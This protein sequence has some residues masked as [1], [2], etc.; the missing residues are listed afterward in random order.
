MAALL[1]SLSAVEGLLVAQDFDAAAELAKAL[2]RQAASASYSFERTYFSERIR[3]DRR[4]PDRPRVMKGRFNKDVGTTGEM[5]GLSL[6]RVGERVAYSE[7]EGAW[8][9]VGAPAANSGLKVEFRF[10]GGG[11]RSSGGDPRLAVFD[12]PHRRLAGAAKVESVKADEETSGV[13]GIECLVLRGTL[14]A[15]GIEAILKAAGAEPEKRQPKDGEPPPSAPELFG[16]AAFWVDDG[17]VVRK[18]EVVT[19]V[20]TESDKGRS[21]SRRT[22]TVTFEG[23]GETTVELPR[24]AELALREEPKAP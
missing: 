3:G 6:A 5:E 12:A 17:W 8:K 13:G 24:G 2:E 9:V 14:K 1:L 10:G 20:F 16:T 23:Y 22:E 15:E 19:S 21:E 7:R 11:G 4:N 18:I